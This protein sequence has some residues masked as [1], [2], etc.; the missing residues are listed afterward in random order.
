MRYT[1]PKG[2]RDV[3]PSEAE[4]WQQLEGLFHSLAELYGYREIR[5][6]IF[7]RTEL[8]LRGLGEVTDIVQKEMFT[9]TDRGGRSLTLRP[10]LPA[11]TVRAFLE[12][13][14]AEEGPVCKFRYFGP[15][16]R[17]ERPQAGRYQQFTQY[18]VECFGSRDPASDAEVIDLAMAFLER[19]GLAA[20]EL[21]LNSIGCPIC[22]PAYRSRLLAY[23]TARVGELCPLC[24][25]RMEKNPLRILDCKSP[26]CRA[27]VAAAPLTVEH[28]CP[29]CAEHF[30][31]V[32]DYLTS[33][34]RSFILAPHL[35]RGLDYYTNTV[36]EVVAP[37]LGAQDAVIGGGR[38]DGLIETCGGPPT[39]GVGFAGGLER[40]LL[41]LAA[42]GAGPR[43]KRVPLVF[44]APLGA[45][46]KE[47]AVRLAHEM[48]TTGLRVDLDYRSRSLKA[49]LREADRQGARVVVILGEDELARG[50]AALKWLDGG[51]QEEI[52]LSVLVAYLR[53]KTCSE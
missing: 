38:Y 39:P 40:L 8:F 52:D 44:L 13:N 31:A 15:A 17:Q 27:V 16:F 11:G 18:G 7:E 35:V 34:G 42:A 10:E 4:I 9:F 32:K 43:E 19:A 14:L 2:T 30:A 49:Q 46:P 28:L 12:H 29:A 5:T 37:G 33:L 53:E 41:A 47:L 23:L 6:P 3:L 48:R 51:G 22:R 36:F 24:R 50:K 21:R 25:E 45:A 26:S 20:V 1:A